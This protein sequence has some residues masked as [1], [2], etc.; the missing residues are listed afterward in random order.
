LPKD[1]EVAKQA[2]LFEKSAQ[3]LFAP[4]RAV[5][6]RR[7][8]TRREAEQKVFWFFFSKKNYLPSLYPLRALFFAHKKETRHGT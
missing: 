8:P 6:A 2:A 7:G 1:A 3:K 5:L 4:L